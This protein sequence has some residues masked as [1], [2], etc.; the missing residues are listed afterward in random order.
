MS[1]SRHLYRRVP[2]IIG[3]VPQLGPRC[4][5]FVG[6]QCM[7][8]SSG[9]RPPIWLDRIQIILRPQ[10]VELVGWLVV[11][12]TH[13]PEIWTPKIPKKGFIFTWHQLLRANNG[14]M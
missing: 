11:K 5:P 6:R 2:G 13:P 3:H 4:S 12:I 10:H 1:V 7:I 8:K 9:S 14:V